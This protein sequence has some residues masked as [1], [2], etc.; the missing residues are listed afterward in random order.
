G[1]QRFPITRTHRAPAWALPTPV[2]AARGRS[3]SVARRGAGGGFTHRR[4]HHARARL[5]RHRPRLDALAA[6]P[7]RNGDVKIF[8]EVMAV[9]TIL[10]YP[11]KR[12][13][14][15]AQLVTRFDAELAQLIEDM[16][17]TMYAAP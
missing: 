3:E 8:A 9:R 6:L 4:R 10:H 16:A 11:D 1:A 12:L 14:E 15:V 5:T 2:F 17:E 13:R 7:R